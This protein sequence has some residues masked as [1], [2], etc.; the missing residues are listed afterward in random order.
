M[1]F[2]FQDGF[3][4]TLGLPGATMLRAF[5]SRVIIALSASLSH[6][7]DEDSHAYQI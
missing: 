5:P 4:E 2:L 3:K 7:S 6:G 1:D